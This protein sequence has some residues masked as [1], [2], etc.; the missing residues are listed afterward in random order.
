MGAGFA[1]WKAPTCGFCFHGEMD[2][3]VGA[4]CCD[5]DDGCTGENVPLAA[6]LGCAA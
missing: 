2:A 1:R 5:W 6:L 3:N 4:P